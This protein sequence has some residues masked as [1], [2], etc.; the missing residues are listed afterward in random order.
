MQAS[1]PPTLPLTHCDTPSGTAVISSTPDLSL[2]VQHKALFN[3]E[4]ERNCSGTAHC[5]EICVVGLLA[6]QDRST[7]KCEYTNLHGWKEQ[8]QLCYAISESSEDLGYTCSGWGCRIRRG[9]RRQDP[10]LVW[11]PSTFSEWSAGEQSHISAPTLSWVCC[12]C[13]S[14]TVCLSWPRITL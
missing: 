11:Y 7:V 14:I 8:N 2:V 12:C 3:Q 4:S 1:S 5:L 9:W 6:W 13:I 10:L